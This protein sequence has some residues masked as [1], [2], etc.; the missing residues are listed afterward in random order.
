MDQLFP[1]PKITI[2]GLEYR[3]DYLNQAQEA[4]LIAAID[5]QPWLTDLK[6]RVQHYGYRYNYKARAVDGPESYLGPLPKWITPLLEKISGDKLIEQ[7]PDQLIVNEYEPG[8]G[9]SPHIDCVPCFEETIFS[10]SLGSA[11]VMDF[12]DAQTSQKTTLLLE[13]RNL[14]ILRGEARYNWKHAILPRKIDLY[15]G[16]LIQ[17]SR[18][19]SL[20]FR[21]ICPN[22]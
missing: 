7:L 4:W 6:R 9:I 11:C 16:Q 19:L 2:P 8:Q 5:R 3:S 10:L 13:P 22:I 18:R 21:N 15:Q 20:T 17:R 12:T 1:S 14:L